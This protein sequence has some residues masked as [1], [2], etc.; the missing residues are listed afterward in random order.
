MTN[1]I[2]HFSYGIR[3]PRLSIS[4][5]RQQ[6]NSLLKAAWFHHNLAVHAGRGFKGIRNHCHYP[7]ETSNKSERKENW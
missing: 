7:S 4:K 1:A 6:G 3:I 2:R 5:V